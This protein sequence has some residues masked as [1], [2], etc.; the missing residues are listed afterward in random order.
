MTLRG[1]EDLW[2]MLH[3]SLC[4]CAEGGTGNVDSDRISQGKV[5]TKAPP[6][7]GDE[8]RELE[9][10]W[11][12]CQSSNDRNAVLKATYALLESRVLPK[13]NPRALRGTRDWREAIASDPR[14]SRDVAAMFGVEKTTVLRYRKEFRAIRRHD[15]V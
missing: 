14:S 2:A 6:P 15:G 7:A 5:S 4:M 8:L 13:P 9:R 3:R 11:E 12:N 10:R 1:Q